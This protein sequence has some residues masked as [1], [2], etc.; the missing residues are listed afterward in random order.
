MK[1]LRTD[2]SRVNPTRAIST[3]PYMSGMVGIAYNR[4]ATGR[5]ITKIC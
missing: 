4:A 1:N 3:A 2:L 5:D